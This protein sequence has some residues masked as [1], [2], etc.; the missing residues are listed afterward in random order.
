MRIV[1]GRLTKQYEEEPMFYNRVGKGKGTKISDRGLEI[2]SGLAPN[3]A[4]AHISD[5]A[6]LPAGGSPAVRR[7]QVY[8]KNYV[9]VAK[10]SGAAIDAINSKDVAYVSDYLQYVLDE[11]V[12]QAYKMCNI[13][14]YGTGNG[15]LATISATATSATQTVNNNDANRYLRDGLVIDIVNTTTNVPE[16]TALTIDNAQASSTT[17]TLTASTTATT[18]N[19]VVASGGYNLA[20]TGLKQIIDDTTNGSTTFQGLSRQTYPKYK[21]FK[22]GA[23]SLGLDVSYLRRLLGAGIHINV[24]QLNRNNLEFWSHPAQ[25]SAYNALGWPLKRTD[26][27]NMTV[28]LGYTVAEYEGINWV[29]DVDCSKD[30]IYAIDFSTMF[31][32]EGKAPGWDDKTGAILRQTPSSTAG[33]YTDQYEAYWTFRY[34]Y[35]CYRPNKNAWIDSLAVPTGF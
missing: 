7:A 30:V 2:P 28:E 21:A 16:Q 12:S 4:H 34:N 29:Q 25:W 23:G 13:Y 22:V 31:K 18:P 17:F 15:R 10:M 27:K 14:A 3:P 24:G 5:G 20:V 32:V 9:H 1:G 6:T 8:F 35:G 26:M 33:R 19:I 11:T